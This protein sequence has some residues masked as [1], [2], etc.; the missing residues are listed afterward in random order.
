[1]TASH[2]GTVEAAHWNEDRGCRCDPQGAPEREN[3]GAVPVDG[4]PFQEVVR[5]L[6]TRMPGGLSTITRECKFCDLLALCAN[7]AL[8]LF[9]IQV[10][11]HNNFLS[12]F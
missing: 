5:A 10:L 3:C 12:E 7:N 1:M 4:L 6:A 11:V 9:V 2:T 8:T